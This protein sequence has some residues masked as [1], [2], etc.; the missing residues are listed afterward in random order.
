VALVALDGRPEWLALAAARYLTPVHPLPHL[1]LF[2]PGQLGYG[3][4]VVIIATVTLGRWLRRGPAGGTGRARRPDAG[5]PGLI[6]SPGAGPAVPVRTG[7]GGS[8]LGDLTVR[9][10]GRYAGAAVGQQDQIPGDDDAG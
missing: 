10:L 6:P 9:A 8:G 1:T 7:R 4:A 3:G 5:E 2:Q